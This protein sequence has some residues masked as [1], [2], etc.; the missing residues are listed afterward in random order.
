MA[1]PVGLAGV[2]ARPLRY[3]GQVDLLCSARMAENG[4]WSY[5]EKKVDRLQ[6]ILFCCEFRVPPAETA[7]PLSAPDYGREQTLLRHLPLFS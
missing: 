2:R 7:A 3:Y 4:Y 5:G 1:R 6:Q